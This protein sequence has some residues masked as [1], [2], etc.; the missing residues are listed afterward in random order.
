MSLFFPERG[1]SPTRA[2]V[3]LLEASVEAT[4]L[5]EKNW[6]R[7]RSLASAIWTCSLLVRPHQVWKA[8]Q[9]ENISGAG[10][11]VSAGMMGKRKRGRI[12]RRGMVA[13]EYLRSVEE[14]SV[15]RTAM[16]AATREKSASLFVSEM[17]F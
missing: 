15:R 14:Q 12:K 7:E 11:R 17:V 16:P 9:R 2:W 1:T 10:G 13:R 6:R 4:P 8:P 3:E 5:K